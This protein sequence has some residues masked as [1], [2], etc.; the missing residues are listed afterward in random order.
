MIYILKIT[1]I[2][3]VH[4][5]CI[6]LSVPVQFSYFPENEVKIKVEYSDI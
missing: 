3:N 4:Y 2:K 1:N 5:I 6:Y